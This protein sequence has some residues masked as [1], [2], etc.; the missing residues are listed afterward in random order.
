MSEIDKIKAETMTLF[1]KVRN[2]QTHILVNHDVQ[3]CDMGYPLS[4]SEPLRR[5]LGPTKSDEYNALDKLAYSLG[6][7]VRELEY[8]NM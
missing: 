4:S 5:K 1:H 2:L 7:G 6:D 8:L 3:V